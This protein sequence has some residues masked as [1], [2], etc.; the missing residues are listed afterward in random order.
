[1]RR[2]T[3][4]Y[5]FGAALNAFFLLYVA[6]VIV[7][8]AI[9]ITALPAVDVSVVEAKFHPLVPS[10][11]LAGYFVFAALGL[12][13]VWVSMWAAYVFAGGRL[14]VDSDAFRPVAA[15]D[16]AFLAPMLVSGG[17]LLWRKSAWGV[18]VASI[19][20][21]QASIYLLVL[22]L[23]SA[24]AIG[25]GLVASPGEPSLWGPLLLF[26]GAATV[27]LFLSLTERQEPQLD[28][29]SASE[30]RLALLV[31]PATLLC[32]AAI[33]MAG[34]RINDVPWANVD[35]SPFPSVLILLFTC[36][37]LIRWVPGARRRN[38]ARKSQLE[39]LVRELDG[40]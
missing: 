9:L 28:N 6:A 14:P 33:F 3:T 19:A 27:A 24:I 16:R 12:A 1:M 11:V 10:R 8:A 13:S 5:L 32:G 37:L 4:P 36:L 30:R 29:E 17:V 20:S 25:R 23:N 2:T 26:T 35:W 18:P 40:H 39:T 7:A 31:V 34:H 22:S 38:V 15:L 21:A